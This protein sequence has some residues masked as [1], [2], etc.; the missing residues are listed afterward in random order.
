[1]RS[2]GDFLSGLP[3]G[4]S[5]GLRGGPTQRQRTEEWVAFGVVVVKDGRDWMTAAKNVGMWHRGVERERKH[6]IT[7]GDARTF[8]NPT[9]GASARLV[10]LYS[11]YLCVQ[12]YFM[13][14][15]VAVVSNSWRR[16]PL[17]ATLTPAS[18]C[19]ISSLFVCFVL[20][21]SCSSFILEQLTHRDAS[22]VC[23]P[24]FFYF[25]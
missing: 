9:C 6:S 18:F 15:L 19:L 22:C 1:M 24:H 23:I 14:C 13:I 3:P 25:I 11:S 12:F 5:R 10:N 16:C 8:A 17:L 4:K 7:P 20:Y 2:T 21:G